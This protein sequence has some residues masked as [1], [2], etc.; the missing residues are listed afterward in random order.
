[1][2]IQDH[3]MLEKTV[4]RGH[5]LGVSPRYLGSLPRLL[6]QLEG[7][8]EVVHVEPDCKIEL[9]EQLSSDDARETVVADEP[10]DDGAVLLLNPGPVSYT[11]L[12]AHETRHD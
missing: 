2:F 10:P 5:G 6:K 1:M 3:G 12:R 7:R 11:H 8:L 4:S 9:A